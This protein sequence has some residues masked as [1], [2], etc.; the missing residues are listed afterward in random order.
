MCYRLLCALFLC[1][2]FVIIKL[3]NH[4]LGNYCFI[5]FQLLA[6]FR[7]QQIRQR[8]HRVKTFG[9]PFSAKSPH[10]QSVECC[11]LVVMLC[12]FCVC[13]IQRKADFLSKSER[14]GRA[15]RCHMRERNGRQT[16]RYCNAL[17]NEAVNS[18][19]TSSHFKISFCD[20]K[21]LFHEN[22]F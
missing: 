4:T 13:G 19:I 15:C 18:P 1:A 20:F 12:L 22:K 10:Y 14:G 9:C 2:F 8:E 6:V 3:S 16:G 17:R 7:M 21:S 11:G 5:F